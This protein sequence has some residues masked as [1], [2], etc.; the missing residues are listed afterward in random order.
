MQ[1]NKN[2]LKVCD[3]ILGKLYV[4]NNHPLSI[5]K[6]MNVGNYDIIGTLKDFEPFLL[7]SLAEVINDDRYFS[8]RILTKNGIMGWI[9]VSANELQFA[10]P[11]I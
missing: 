3:L 11:T 4:F 5:F 10:K 1:N 7:L 8:C 2:T 9:A 6:N